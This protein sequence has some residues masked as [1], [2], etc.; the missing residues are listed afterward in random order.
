M[1]KLDSHLVSGPQA[2]VCPSPRPLPHSVSFLGSGLATCRYTL[3]PAAN[4]KWLQLSSYLS[5]AD[6]GAYWS[7]LQA[8]T[9]IICLKAV[10]RL[11]GL[12]LG[13]PLDSAPHKLQKHTAERIKAF[14]HGIPTGN[15][16]EHS[17][18]DDSNRKTTRTFLLVSSSWELEAMYSAREAGQWESGWMEGLSHPSRVIQK[19]P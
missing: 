12:G 4:W 3:F 11:G 10:G 14:L 17:C 16:R 5:V 6:A 8:S 2:Q 9:L 13:I 19:I 7:L 1:G 18:P 15:P